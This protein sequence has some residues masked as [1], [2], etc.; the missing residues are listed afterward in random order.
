MIRLN[1][2][3][4]PFLLIFMWAAAPAVFGQ[5]LTYSVPEKYEA[6]QTNFDIIGKY[7]ENVLVYKNFRDKNY[8]SVYDRD[9]KVIDNVD[10]D[11][12]PNRLIEASFVAH[13]DFSYLFFQYNQRGIVHLKAV[14]LDAKGNKLTEPMEIDTTVVG[15]NNDDKIYS[16]LPSEDKSK[17]LIFRI[18]TKNERRFQ[19]KT[20]LF[21]KELNLQHSSRLGLDMAERND[22]LTD[23]LIDNDG[24]LVFGKGIRLGNADNINKFFLVTKP[25]N[26]DQFLF[27]ELQFENISL[28]EVKLKI[29]NFNKRYLFTGFYYPGRKG[30][31]EGVATA[32]FDRTKLEWVVRT[33]TPFDDQLREDNRGNQNFKNAFNDF[34]IH[35][36]TIR[37]DG[38]FLI[39][40]ESNYQ[41]NRGG[42]MP[43]NRW[44]MMNPWMGPMGWGGGWG[45]PWGWGGSPWGWGSP[46]WGSQN[47]NTRFHADNIIVMAFDK[48]GKL[49][50]S[51]Q[52]VKSQFDDNS[53]NAISYF[54]ANTGNGLQ[55]I[56]NDYES[57]NLVLA[58]QTLNPEGRV[59]R[60]PTMKSL[61]RDYKFLPRLSK[62]IDR[63]TI[64][65][66]CL[67]RNSLCFARMEFPA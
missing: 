41:S 21:D 16:I 51:N 29:D 62:Q 4:R 57:R 39:N 31:I 43:F 25:Y 55:Y 67:Y 35:E 7:G 38:A 47:N 34:F 37:S 11:F 58:Y 33:T 65:I 60:N 48:N 63:K 10:L 23:F 1:A 44:D 9:M 30:S 2:F 64:I 12:L 13:P 66:P 15:T 18:N 14:K 24:N 50:L 49:L 53:A 45:T 61:E 56:Y 17:L 59:I 36:V 26:Q 46:W 42:G 5:K 6:R 52:V 3:C 19:F 40:A 54:M 27:R 8:I 28:D 32:I 22:F 20:L